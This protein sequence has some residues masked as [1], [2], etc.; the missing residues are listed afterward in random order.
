VSYSL[1]VVQRKE[2]MPSA[3]FLSFHCQQGDVLE[4]IKIRRDFVIKKYS[5]G[6]ITSVDNIYSDCIQNVMRKGFLAGISCLVGLLLVI[7]KWL[8]CGFEVFPFPSSQH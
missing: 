3:H 4:M 7:A 2:N 6:V 1:S 8:L 5:R